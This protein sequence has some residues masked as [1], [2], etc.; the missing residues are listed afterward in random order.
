MTGR[1]GEEKSVRTRDAEEG[2]RDERW[3][4]SGAETTIWEVTKK[5]RGTALR[6]VSAALNN[7]RSGTGTR[8]EGTDGLIKNT[9]Y[10]NET[11]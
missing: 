11:R 1:Q 4:S 9:T 8:D 7:R 3:W 2:A 10:P 5:G 6:L